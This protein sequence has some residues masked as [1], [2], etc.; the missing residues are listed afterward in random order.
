MT[1]SHILPTYPRAPISFERGEGSWLIDRE[2][3][4]FLDMGSGVAVTAL[5]HAEPGVVRALQEQAEKL[6]HT[7]N[8]YT[9]ARQEE[10]ASKLCAATFAETVF[11]TNSGAEAMECAF[12]MARK[13]WAAQNQPGRGR[14][15][16]FHGAF[17]GRT[18]ATISAVGSE[19]LTKGFEPLLEG[20]VQI[21][22][23]DWGA[24]QQA[25]GSRTGS[26]GGAGAVVVEPIQGEGGIL[27]WA[28]ADLRRLREM[29]DEVEALLIFDEIQCGMGRS[30]HLFAHQGAGVT[31]DIMAVAK[32]IGNGF[33]LGACLASARAGEA[34][35]VGTHGS[36]YGGN[37]LACA[38]GMAVLDRINT[39]EFLS[40][41][42]RKS[43][44]LRHKLE[45][46]VEAHP[47]VFEQLR[48]VGMMLGIKCKC[49]NLDL[50]AACQEQQMLLIPGGDNVVRVL[51]ALSI[52]DEDINEASIRLDRAATVLEGT[53]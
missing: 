22:P 51:P 26:D 29:C 13:Y 20:F 7:S 37:P 40:Q 2:G 17:H 44:L 32:G 27:P 25:L 52:S 45:A 1:E 14:I 35:T 15:I 19:K 50:V 18:L 36:T 39:P 10:L 53:L 8:L 24:L 11:F 34:M 3:R 46:C 6:W 41:V 38:V 47:K 5:G 16:T 23:G 48:G 21:A 4:R 49:S 43:A 31:P 12:K 42:R 9:I 28:E 30:G 33:P